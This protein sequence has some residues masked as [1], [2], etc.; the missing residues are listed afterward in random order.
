MNYIDNDLIIQS[1]DCT[2]YV[3]YEVETAY[4]D[5]IAYIK[6]NVIYLMV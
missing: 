2:R 6:R 1:T 3:T 5:L 4:K